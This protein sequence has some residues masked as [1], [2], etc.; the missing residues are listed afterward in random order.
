M[1]GPRTTSLRV[2]TILTRHDPTSSE[3]TAPFS[4]TLSSLPSRRA[5][6]DGQA[7]AARA[8]STG[9]S[10]GYGCGIGRVAGQLQ[11]KSG[12]RRGGVSWCARQRSAGHRQAGVGK[13]D[14]TGQ[15]RAGPE[16]A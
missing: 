2:L 10:Q 12:R 4:L 1:H 9:G 6:F 14:S 16:G 8:S 11:P 5:G 3:S 7:R 13:R 15:A